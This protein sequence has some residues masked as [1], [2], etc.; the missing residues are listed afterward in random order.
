MTFPGSPKQLPCRVWPSALVI[1]LPFSGCILP[2][3]QH[4]EA[5]LDV[6]LLAGQSI[7]LGF[8]TVSADLPTDPADKRILASIGTSTP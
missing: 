2:S 1:L 4:S 5:V 7:A 6:V 3:Q 8:D